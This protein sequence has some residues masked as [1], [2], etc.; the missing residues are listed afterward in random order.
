MGE[1]EEWNDKRELAQRDEGEGSKALGK[2]EARNEKENLQRGIG[3]E[4][5]MTCNLS[6]YTCIHNS[7]VLVW[8]SHDPFPPTPQKKKRIKKI[9]HQ[10]KW[11]WSNWNEMWKRW[12]CQINHQHDKKLTMVHLFLHVYDGNRK[13]SYG[14][15]LRKNKRN[16]GC[17]TTELTPEVK[18]EWDRKW[19]C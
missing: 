3:K 18:R 14:E 1:P 15:L 4:S 10:R 12:K 19:C 17:R 6:W 7:K 16:T 11:K 9:S 8:E 13:L 2:S 5:T